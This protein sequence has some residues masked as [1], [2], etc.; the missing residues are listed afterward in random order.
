LE[1]SKTNNTT[2]MMLRMLRHVPHVA[3]RC[4]MRRTLSRAML[5][6]LRHMPHVAARDATHACSCQCCG[7]SRLESMQ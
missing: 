1:K 3:A 5:R 6:T 2:H 7:S 4:V